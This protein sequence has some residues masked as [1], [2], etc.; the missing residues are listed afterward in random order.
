ML[1]I[2]DL[3]LSDLD[4]DQLHPIEDDHLAQLKKRSY[5]E[6]LTSISHEDFIAK[7][8]E[9]FLSTKINNVTGVQ[10]FPNVDIIMGCTH[11]IESL[12]SRRKWNIQILEKEYVYYQL[13]GKRSTKIGQLEPGV[14]LIVSLPNY[15]YGNRPDWEAVLKECEQKE[16]DIHIDCAWL[17]AAK[18]FELDLDH[19][20]IK[21][22]AMSTSKYNMAWNRIGLRWSKQ[23]TMDS[24]T[25]INQQRKYYGLSTACGA[26]LM[27]NIARDYGWSTYGE[28]NK[29]ICDKL[30]LEPTMYFY[31]VKDKDGKLYSLGKVLGKIKL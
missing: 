16:I 11:Y 31:V 30:D 17:I 20:N 15:Y 21:S 4:S 22:F 28:L 10:K 7:S 2:H 8:K 18:G 9:W 5:A 3:K 19:P 6:P 1:D 24:V 12:A 13:M 26:F 27:D 25:L 14:P 23:R 29:V